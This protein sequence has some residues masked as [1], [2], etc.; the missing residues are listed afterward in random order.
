M[1]ISE[2]RRWG[3]LL[4]ILADMADVE[5]QVVV[6]GVRTAGFVPD[7]LLDRWYDTFQGGHGMLE[8]GVSEDL[9][10]I[11]LDFD[12]NLEDLMDIVP[13][14]AP[15]RENYIR[16]DAAWRAIRELADWTVTRIAEASMPEEETFSTN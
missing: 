16:N 12:Y 10:G 9:L 11:L 2:P 14:D 1:D 6:Q 13:Q 7:E 8:T 15:D 5:R 4:D 3:L